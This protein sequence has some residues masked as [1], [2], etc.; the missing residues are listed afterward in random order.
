MLGHQMQSTQ[1]FIELLD[2][3][4]SGH[5]L[6]EVW[7][8]GAVNHYVSVDAEAARVRLVRAS[9]QAGEWQWPIVPSVLIQEGEMIRH[10]LGG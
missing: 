5:C 4:S 1:P 8:R 7:E 6:H 9:I 2:A 10:S 3:L